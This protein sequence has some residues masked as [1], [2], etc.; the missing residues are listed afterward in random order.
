MKP[1]W[2]ALGVIGGMALIVGAI[3]LAGRPEQPGDVE[4]AKGPSSLMKGMRERAAKERALERQRKALELKNALRM[5][6]G[7]APPSH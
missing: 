7:A 6:L 5:D 4:S 3:L 1:L 2:I